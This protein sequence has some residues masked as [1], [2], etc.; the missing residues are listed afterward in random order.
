MEKLTQNTGR[1][2]PTADKH[3]RFQDGPH[4]RPTHRSLPKLNIPSYRGPEPKEIKPNQ[5]NHFM[6]IMAASS[7]APDPLLSLPVL[8]ASS[9]NNFDLLAFN[10][11]H[12][13]YLEDLPTP[14]TLQ[15]TKIDALEIEQWKKIVGTLRE[16]H[17]AALDQLHDNPRDSELREKVRT[18]RAE[19]EKN[20]NAV[21][22][23]YERRKIR[24]FFRKDFN[25]LAPGW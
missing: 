15:F 3:N 5:A 14:P 1:V 25:N 13:P 18:L 24:I 11:E 4:E 6:N 21:A 7:P 9:A 2:L 17:A 16:T 12:D 22:L 20:V 19:R 10:V 8:P 23:A